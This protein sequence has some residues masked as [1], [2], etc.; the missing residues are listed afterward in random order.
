MEN[1]V[2]LLL[3][4]DD[5]KQHYPVVLKLLAL[6]EG[7]ISKNNGNFYSLNC[8]HPFRTG[9]KEEFQTEICQ[10]HNCCQVH[11]SDDEKT[12]ILKYYEGDK[13][14][15]HQS[16]IYVHFQTI[17]EKI[18]TFSFKV[19]LSLSKDNT[20]SFSIS[21]RFVHNESKSKNFSIELLNV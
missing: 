9:K 5:P 8:L 11:I 17:L 18:E 3:I 12:N 13:L 14:L 6:L 20:C 2:I 4:T 10:N 1:Q 16:V 7:V 19:S 21:I 15:R